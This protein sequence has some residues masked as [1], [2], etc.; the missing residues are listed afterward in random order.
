[1]PQSNK[2]VLLRLF[3]LQYIVHFYPIIWLPTC[4]T[5][6]TECT[7]GRNNK[8]LFCSYHYRAAFGSHVKEYLQDRYL[9]EQLQCEPQIDLW[10]R[11]AWGI[12]PVLLTLCITKGTKGT[13]TCGPARGADTQ[14]HSRS[15]QPPDSPTFRLWGWK[16]LGVPLFTVSQ[17][18]QLE[19]LL[20]YLV[21][22][23]WSNYLKDLDI[24]DSVVE[25]LGSSRW[26]NLVR[27]GGVKEP[28]FQLRWYD[29][30]C[31]RGLLD[32]QTGLFPNTQWT[33]A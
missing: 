9:S 10:L 33:D 5:L 21:I 6:L 3:Q 1:M 8:N 15:P 27:L 12:A 24:W 26:G 31:A 28:Q 32:A 7:S 22:S 18:H 29:S 16:S 11:R 30:D 19:L 2:E 25:S 4:H 13:G 17:R 14:R 20:W 23:P